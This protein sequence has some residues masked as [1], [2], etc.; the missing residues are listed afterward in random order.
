MEVKY[1]ARDGVFFMTE[2]ECIQYEKN[3]E[4]LGNEMI[5]IIKVLYDKYLV[6]FSFKIYDNCSP[7]F[8]KEM[9]EL[10]EI[11]KKIYFEQ[12][13][14]NIQ[15][16]L[17]D[18]FDKESEEY[19]KIIW[20]ADSISMKFIRDCIVVNCVTLNEAKGLLEEIK[21]IINNS[22]FKDDIYEAYSYRYH[23]LSFN[24]IL[25]EMEIRE[26]FEKYL[27]NNVMDEIYEVPSRINY[28]LTKDE[29]KTLIEIHKK[30]KYRRKIETI[31]DFLEMDEIV[32]KLKKRDYNG[33]FN[34]MKC[35]LVGIEYYNENDVEYFLRKNTVADFIDMMESDDID[36]PMMDYR[37]KSAW[38]SDDNVAKN[39][40]FETIE[41]F[42]NYCKRI[43]NDE[44]NTL[45]LGC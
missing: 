45:K 44:K 18:S 12:E 10:M 31:F 42:Y 14:R 5:E 25:K 7:Q 35:G 2:D 13:K 21:E 40:N 11:N 23:T 29:I 17:D 41:G 24:K 37:V 33:K 34:M 19:K 22:K 20:D 16:I 39:T 32:K 38:I 6:K 43:L 4:E 28:Q 3:R 1:Y 36:I 9:K 26:N 30:G 27:R 8:Y 15:I